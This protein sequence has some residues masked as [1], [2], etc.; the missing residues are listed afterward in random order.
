MFC[1]SIADKF[2]GTNE[3][4]TLSEIRKVL[5]KDN[6]DSRSSENESD[7]E[8]EEEK[9]E[10]LLIKDLKD[11]KNAKNM[12][13]L[14][15]DF[16]SNSYNLPKITVVDPLEYD[17]GVDDVAR[18]LNILNVD[19]CIP[20]HIENNEYLDPLD[21]RIL[22]SLSSRNKSEFG[23]LSADKKN[24]DIQELVPPNVYNTV[25]LRSLLIKHLHFK[26]KK[27]EIS[28]LASNVKNPFSQLRQFI[29]NDIFSYSPN[30]QVKIEADRNLFYRRFHALFKWPALMTLQNS[31]PEL[32]NISEFL[33]V[34]KITQVKR[35][36][37]RISCHEHNENAKK[38]KTT[39]PVMKPLNVL[40]LTPVSNKSVIQ[41]LMTN[42]SKKL[43][44]VNQIN[45]NGQVKTVINE[46]K[47]DFVEENIVM[48]NAATSVDKPTTS[49]VT[50]LT[51][52]SKENQLC[53]EVDSNKK[54]KDVAKLE[55][56]SGDLNSFSSGPNE[57]ILEGRTKH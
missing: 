8:E 14:L 41:D 17:K 57:D 45:E 1:R 13:D 25:G 39:N 47:L 48:N 53:T 37:S 55:D 23:N 34:K 3:I 33:P 51:P 12:D 24:C 35:T 44:S 6:E 40:K 20:T 15:L 52:H 21:V 27:R 49:S 30:D 11:V 19:L 54:S 43:F 7:N 10:S 32:L 36:Y 4:P 29:A 42:K 50:K 2:S 31:S 16:F 5:N 22:H 18:V 26:N 9:E 28:Q 56:V 46:I 38:L